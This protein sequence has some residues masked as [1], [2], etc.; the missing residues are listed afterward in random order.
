MDATARPMC[1]SCISSSALRRSATIHAWLLSTAN[2]TAIKDVELQKQH[3]FNG[4]KWVDLRS[5]RCDRRRAQHP[6]LLSYL[7]GL[8]EAHG[9]R[10][11][12]TCC[13]VV[14]VVENPPRSF[15]FKVSERPKF[16][17][18]DI[19]VFIHADSFKCFY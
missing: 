13:Q 10:G 7:P 1:A 6:Y 18:V 19:S 2:H 15:S 3:M 16:E 12:K 8:V 9:G 17:E 5:A 4:E 14:P 11:L